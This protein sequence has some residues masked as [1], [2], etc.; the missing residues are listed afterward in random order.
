M[1]RAPRPTPAAVAADCAAAFSCDS[2]PEPKSTQYV[3]AL[4]GA[5]GAVVG[6]DVVGC[7]V[8]G[9]GPQHDQC[10]AVVTGQMVPQLQDKSASKSVIW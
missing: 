1:A 6:Y 8:V 3:G 10:V 7:D 2:S 4:V 5:E 9:A